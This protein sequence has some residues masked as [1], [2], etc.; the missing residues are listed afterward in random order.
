MD[1]QQQQN[2][3]GSINQ[4]SSSIIFDLEAQNVIPNPPSPSNEATEGQKNGRMSKKRIPITEIATNFASIL[5][6]GWQWHTIPF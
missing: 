6:A 4:H 1:Q 5:I 3:M 2:H